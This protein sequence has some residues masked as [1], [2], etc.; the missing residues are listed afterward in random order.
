MPKFSPKNLKAQFLA[1]AHRAPNSLSKH[2]A[3]E[4][5]APT[6]FP[7]TFCTI[8]VSKPCTAPAV[9]NELY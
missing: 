7:Q 3:P 4:P 2:A 9:L 6:A 5:P 1:K 8:F